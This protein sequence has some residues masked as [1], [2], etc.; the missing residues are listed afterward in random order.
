MT[1]AEE[2][3]RI[4]TVGTLVVSAV[5]GATVL[6][7]VGGH[8]ILGGLLFGVPFAVGAGILIVK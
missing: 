2:A 4:A 1:K 3:I 7:M 8:L 5:V 6:F